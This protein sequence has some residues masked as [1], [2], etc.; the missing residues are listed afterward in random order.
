MNNRHHILLLTA[1]LVAG[2]LTGAAGRLAAANPAPPLLNEP[3]DVSGDFRDFSNL[4]YLADR[5]A[6]FDPATGAGQ[7]TWQRSQYVTRQAFDNMLAFGMLSSHSRCH[8][9]APKEPWNYGPAFMDDFRRIDELKY[10]LMPYVY[11]QAKDSAERGPPMVRALF[12]DFP[13]DPGAWLVDDEYLFGSS[14]LVAPLMHENATNRDVYLPPENWIDYQTGKAW[15]GGWQKIEAGKLPIVMLVRDGTA[16]PQ[17]QPAQSTLQ[18]D[19]SKLELVVFA[20]DA[21]TVKGLVYRPGDSTMHEL[22]LTKKTGTF[23]LASDPLAGKVTWKI[24]TLET[25][26]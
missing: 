2:I 15:A 16:L 23:K 18:L 21:Q 1:C 26:R 13:E 22:T 5:L 14:I 17:I 8:G 3:I 9:I 12:I 4:Y 24:K 6:A 10:R 25:S 20:R 19:W 7:I 11:A